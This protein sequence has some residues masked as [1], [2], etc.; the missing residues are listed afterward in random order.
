MVYDVEFHE[1]NDELQVDFSEVA[2][3]YSE[4]YEL[5]KKDGY[6]DGYDSGKTEGIAEGKQAEYDAFWDKYQYNGTRVTCETM[7][8]GDGW[9]DA[10]FKPKYNIRPT[11][12][13]MMFRK[14]SI[15]DV[16]DAKLEELGISIDFSNCANYQYFG[17]G[18][19]I[20]HFGTIDMRAISGKS[21]SYITQMFTSSTLLH[22]I[23]KL[24]VDEGVK[25]NADMFQNCIALENITIDGTIA[26]DINLSAC[27]LSVES[28]VS[29]YNSLKSYRGQD[30]EGNDFELD[31]V[32]TKHC[33]VSDESVAK[34]NE[35]Y[36]NGTH[37][38]NDDWHTSLENKGWLY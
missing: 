8:A 19:R 26:S 29:L 7:F 28:M 24:I 27:P 20:R 37:N 31:G 30:E 18:S 35:A 34:W 6:A 1:N 10:I 11:S 12:A 25:F 9:R 36:E 22:T 13:Y 32:E 23:D 33:T 16:S 5:G 21:A 17:A 3:S 14:A 2:S 4:G 38:V 15:T